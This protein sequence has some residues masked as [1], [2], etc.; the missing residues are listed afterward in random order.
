MLKQGVTFDRQQANDEILERITLELEQELA[1]EGRYSLKG[2]L[3]ARGR[4]VDEF[5]RY[6]INEVNKQLLDYYQK[7]C[8][9]AVNEGAYEAEALIKQEIE[10]K[11]L[12]YRN[13]YNDEL[14]DESAKSE[15]Q[16]WAE[17][18]VMARKLTRDQQVRLWDGNFDQ[19]LIFVDKLINAHGMDAG[20]KGVKN[21]NSRKILNIVE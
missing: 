20:R 8:G 21:P 1:K 6:V 9:V 16:A 7:A 15:R 18:L 17:A 3:I 19:L 12:S 2:R 13:N 10:N 11:I 5:S 14:S 4:N